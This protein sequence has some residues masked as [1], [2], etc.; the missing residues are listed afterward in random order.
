MPEFAF[1]ARDSAGHDVVG[2]MTA[3]DKRGVI[4][5]LADRSLCALRVQAKTAINFRWGRTIRVKPR[6]LATNL[7]Q[8]ADLLQNGVP[9]LGALDLLAEQTVSAAFREVLQDI[10]KNVAEGMS[11]DQAFARHPRVF[12]ELAVSMVHAGMEGAFLEDAL[13]RT[14]DFLDLQ[15]DLKGRL[16]GAMTYPAFLAG[17]GTIVT[18]ALIVFFVPKFSTLFTRLER[19]GQGLPA[20]TIVLLAISHV[21]GSYGLF[22]GGALGAVG[23]GIRHALGTPRGKM[24]LD[25]W[26]LKVPIFGKI[27]LGY[28]VSRFC[29]VLGTLL[30]NGVPLLKALEISS[31][32]AGNI[33]LSKAIRQSA[34][35]VS[36][37]D[38]LSRP[39]AGC[40]LIPRPVMAMIT[41]AEQSNS[42]DHVLVDIAGTIDRQNS[43]QIDT[44]VRLVEPLML[45]VMGG[46]IMFIISALLLPVFD[47]SA[48]LGS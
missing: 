48:V 15:E 43:R 35:N 27:F 47:M 40:G 21:L 14:A 25:R 2:V 1:T 45:L 44:M 22:I 39:L 32:S 23:Y 16:V 42:L 13:R 18:V 46:V 41:V 5:A 29:R 7:A 3:A 37:G 24:F 19:S 4:A 30:K 36:A 9:L 34:E 10:R 17:V 8:L 28:A 12:G 26:K 33:V 6:V 11:L 20:V 38:T 31:E